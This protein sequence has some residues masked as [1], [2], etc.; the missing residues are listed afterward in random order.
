MYMYIF[1]VYIDVS[2][3]RECKCE[4]GRRTEIQYTGTLSSR[5]SGL[6]SSP[7]PSEERGG[8]ATSR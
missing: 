2:P 3:I 5:A 7:P 8:N 1:V 6:V 4:A